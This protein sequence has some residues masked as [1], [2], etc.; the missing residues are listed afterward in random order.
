MR[1]AHGQV[2]FTGDESRKRE[3]LTAG[4]D[5]CPEEEEFGRPNLDFPTTCR[6]QQYRG[7][8]ENTLDESCV[9]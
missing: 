9:K 7:E 1:K 8:M 4:W 2:D 3:M 6:L 5:F